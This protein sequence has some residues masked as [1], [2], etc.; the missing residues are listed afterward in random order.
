[1]WAFSLTVQR[2][3]TGDL[4]LGDRQDFI[5]RTAPVD[6]PA[7]DESAAQIQLVLEAIEHMVDS[8]AFGPP[9]VTLN[10]SVSGHS[11]EEHSPKI[12]RPSD[13]V[14]INVSQVGYPADAEHSGAGGVVTAAIAPP[15]VAPEP[16]PVVTYAAPTVVPPDFSGGTQ[17]TMTAEEAK[18]DVEPDTAADAELA[19][20][21]AAA[22]TTDGVQSVGDLAA[23]VE[24]KNAELPDGER[25]TWAHAVE[26]A[27]KDVLDEVRRLL[28]LAP[29]A[30]VTPDHVTTAAAVAET[31][32]PPAGS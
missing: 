29:D 15:T 26:N 16:P 18:A 10:L 13:F 14:T 19:A 7:P 1:M 30:P 5:D 3:A 20:Q 9:G 17:P 24:A 27:P 25:L 32:P 22:P 6:G 21:L 8:G 28:G 12:D 23:V 4:D 31:E 2:P 11:N